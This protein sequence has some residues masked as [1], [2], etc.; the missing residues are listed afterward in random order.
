MGSSNCK[1]AGIERGEMKSGYYYYIL[2]KFK[3]KF[4]DEE[5]RFS[6]ENG[7]NIG[8]NPRARILGYWLDFFTFCATLKKCKAPKSVSKIWPKIVSAS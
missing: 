8:V 1:L 5:S 2:M 3:K 4:D 6:T 7:A